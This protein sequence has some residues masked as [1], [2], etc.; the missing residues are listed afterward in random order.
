[1]HAKTD[2]TITHCA[3][4]HPATY[5]PWPQRERGPYETWWIRH[6]GTN[7]FQRRRAAALAWRK[8]PRGKR[9]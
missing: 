1:M 2:L 8:S 9:P 5:Y 3:A 7:R 4:R 6:D